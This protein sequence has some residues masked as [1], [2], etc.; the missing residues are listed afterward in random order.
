MNVTLKSLLD[1]DVALDIIAYLREIAFHAVGILVVDDF[2]EFFQLRTNLRHLVVGVGV[3]KD[4]LQ[5]I[6]VLIQHTLGNAHVALEGGTRGVLML[7]DSSK[8]EGGDEG[9]T[10]RVSHRLIVLLE[11]YS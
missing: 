7:H 5:Q 9:N 11:V 6:V 2:Q 1:F 8:D 3:E 10:Q 4:F